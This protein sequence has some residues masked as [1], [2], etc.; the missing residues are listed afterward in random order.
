MSVHR[1]IRGKDETSFFQLQPL[2]LLS[3]KPTKFKEELHAL[4]KYSTLVTI[5]RCFLLSIGGPV[6]MHLVNRLIGK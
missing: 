2:L 6:S 4:N 5:W 3:E 1:R